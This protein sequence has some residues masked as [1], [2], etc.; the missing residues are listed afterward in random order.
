MNAAV[1]YSVLTSVTNWDFFWNGWMEMLLFVKNED[2]GPVDQLVKQCDGC[3]HGFWWHWQLQ[4]WGM[5]F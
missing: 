2:T 5:V 1:G 3:E 4:V